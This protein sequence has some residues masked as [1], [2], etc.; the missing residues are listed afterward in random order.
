MVNPEQRTAE[1]HRAGGTGTLPRENDEIGGEVVI[2]G[3]RC[4]V[5]DFTLPPPGVE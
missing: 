4:R 2:P 5:G 3:F 1:I